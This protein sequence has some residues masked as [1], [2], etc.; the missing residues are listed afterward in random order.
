M[1]ISFLKVLL[2][3]EFIPFSLGYELGPTSLLELRFSF[4]LELCWAVTTA[5]S[6]RKAISSVNV[7]SQC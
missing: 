4:L 2:Y 6:V 7:N 5:A 1:V 3:F